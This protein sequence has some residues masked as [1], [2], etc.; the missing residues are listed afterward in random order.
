[1]SSYQSSGITLYPTTSAGTNVTAQLISFGQPQIGQ[2]AP[3]A[4]GP[5]EWLR[6]SVSEITELA[7][8]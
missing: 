6:R 8:A 1:M 7:A 5:L 2:A 3:R 4:E